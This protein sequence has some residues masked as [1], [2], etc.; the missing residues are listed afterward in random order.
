MGVFKGTRS[1]GLGSPGGIFCTKVHTSAKASGSPNGFAQLS[2]HVFTTF[3]FVHVSQDV[4][5]RTFPF[6]KRKYRILTLTM[7]NHG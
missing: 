4:D 7:V 5:Y 6:K 3:T 2:S 1:G